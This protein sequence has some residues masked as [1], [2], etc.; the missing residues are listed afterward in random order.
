MY[1]SHV[2]TRAYFSAVDLAFASRPDFPFPPADHIVIAVV[3]G[4]VQKDQRALFR[5]D[6]PQGGFR[7]RLLR[8]LPA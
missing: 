6:G 7:G 5:R 8:E 3:D 2:G 1:H 4:R